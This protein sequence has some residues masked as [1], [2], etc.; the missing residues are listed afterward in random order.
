MKSARYAV[1]GDI[2]G[3]WE[4]LSTVLADAAEQGVTEYVSVGDVVGYNADPAACLEKMRELNCVVVRGNHDHYCSHEES[5]HDFHP[6]AAKVISWTRDQL[7]EEQIEYLRQL[8]MHV[9]MDGFTLVHSTLDMPDHW[10]YVFDSL[11]AEAHFNYQHTS[12][13]FYGHTH[14][15]VVFDKLGRVTR[16]DTEMLKIEIG[17]KYFIN[18]GSVG[19]PRDGDP[20]C[21]YVIYD[22]E[23][24]TV[25]FRRLT[26]D[27]ATAQAK[28]REAGLPER[29]AERLAIGK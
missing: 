18:V 7:S 16:R 23:A 19:Q 24:K 2:H 20:R 5:L 26:Y 9:S 12:V 14:V 11:E 13:C 21:A 6:L 28:I 27:L 17:H 10:G 15:P 4:A 22:T 25:E 8:K 1:L 3:N 29:L